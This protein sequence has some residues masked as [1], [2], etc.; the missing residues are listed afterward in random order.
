MTFFTLDVG[1]KTNPAG[2][3]L[4]AR[5]VEPLSWWQCSHGHD[6]SRCFHT[7]TN[8]ENRFKLEV[9]SKMARMSNLVSII[10]IFFIRTIARWVF[11]GGLAADAATGPYG[12]TDGLNP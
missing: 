5:I 2:V 9:P 6:L 11:P 10:F 8:D 4:I 1:Y 12:T 7:T 3:M